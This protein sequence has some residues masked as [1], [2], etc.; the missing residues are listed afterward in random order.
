MAGG[1]QDDDMVQSRHTY[2]VEVAASTTADAA[3]VFAMVA[4]GAR[5]SQ[6]AGPLV[7]HS[8][9]ER[10]GDPAPG[11]VGAVRALGRKPFLLREETLEYEQDRRH[12][13]AL[14]TPSPMKDYRGEVTLTPRAGGGTDLLWRVTFTERVPLTGPALRLV[15]RKIINLMTTNLIRAAG[16]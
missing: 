6:W 13:Y 10:L 1:C 7:A 5:W 4:D 9:M 12:V 15:A 11:G 16:R 3:T 14:R 8:S 2:A